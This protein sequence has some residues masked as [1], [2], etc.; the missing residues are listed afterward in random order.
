MRQLGLRRERRTV[1][2]KIEPAELAVERRGQIRDLL[3]VRDV[4]RH[5]QRLIQ[6]RCKLADILLEPLTLIRQRKAGAR[7]SRRLRDRPRD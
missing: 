3:I 4:A 5:H 1:D 2:D 7:R 6:L